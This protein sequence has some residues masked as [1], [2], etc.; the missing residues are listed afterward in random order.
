MVK[1]STFLDHQHYQQPTHQ[2]QYIPQQRIVRQ[3]YPSQIQPAPVPNDSGAEFQEGFNPNE[4]WFDVGL[5][6]VLF[7]H[8]RP[9]KTNS[10]F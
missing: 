10:K 4:G 6:K 8:M 7:L 9:T 2:E 3:Q 5:F 1:L